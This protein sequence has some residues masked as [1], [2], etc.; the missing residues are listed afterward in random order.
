MEKEYQKFNGLK[1]A[2]IVKV[3]EGNGTEDSVAREVVYVFDE[4]LQEI[5]RIDTLYCDN[6]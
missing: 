3:I 6:K 5:G 2:F 1:K 4:N